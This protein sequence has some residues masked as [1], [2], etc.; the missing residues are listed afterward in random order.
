MNSK[1]SVVNL[2]LMNFVALLI[3]LRDSLLS[4]QNDDTIFTRNVYF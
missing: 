2:R 1:D 4:L 3:N